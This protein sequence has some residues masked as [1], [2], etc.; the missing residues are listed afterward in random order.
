[1]EREGALRVGQRLTE[2]E[3]QSKDDVCEAWRG[4]ARTR[5]EVWGNECSGPRGAQARTERKMGARGGKQK[6]SERGREWIVK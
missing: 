2:V 6:E 3:V 4:K 5:G 1:M